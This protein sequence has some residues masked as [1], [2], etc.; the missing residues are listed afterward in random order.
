MKSEV[1]LLISVVNSSQS[2]LHN[3]RFPEYLPNQDESEVNHL[4]SVVNSSQTILLNPRFPRVPNQDEK[5]S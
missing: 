1:N 2:I 5:R 4:I 3:P